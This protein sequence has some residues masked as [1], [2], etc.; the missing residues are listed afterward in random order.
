MGK[1]YDIIVV[2]SGIA[3]LSCAIFLKKKGFS[4]AVLTKNEDPLECNTFY[5]Q[6]GII[7]KVDKDSI[8]LLVNDILLAGNNY[9]YKNAVNFFAEKGPEL[10]PNFL[11]DE[12]GIDFSKTPNGNDIDYTEEA[13]H[14]I[15]RIA[16][17]SDY[18]GEAIEKGL[19]SYAKKIDIKI[20][21]DY[22]AIDLISNTHHSTD[23]QELYKKQIVMGVYALDNKNQK[24]EKILSDKVVLATGGVGNLF[25]YTTN[26]ASA[27]GDGISMAAKAG[28]KIINAE[29]V[30]FHPTML[31]HKDI[32][33]F[34]I[35]ESLRGEGAK[36]IDKNGKTFMQ[37]YSEQ[38]DLAPRDVVSRA[39]FDKMATDAVE[40]VELDIANYYKGE[41]PLKERFA[42]IYQTCKEAGI[43][44]TK[45]KIPVVPGAHYFC[46]G[47][48]VDTNGQSSIEN[49][50]AIGE[51]SCTGLHGSNRLAS[52]SLLEALLWAKSSADDISQN[53]ENTKAKR[54][55]H[56]PD[57]QT[58]KV[59]TTFDPILIKQDWK[60]IK[61]T[62][63]NYAG[64]VRTQKGLERANADLKYFYDRIMRFYSEAT[65]TKDLI[66]LR[67]AVVCSSII[68][69][70]AF[71][72]KN[73]IGC[74]Y[75][76]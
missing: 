44:I 48:K 12:V 64:I 22:S 26:P 70:A 53:F 68:A 58:P 46:G 62:M 49:L 40:Y 28:A 2:G 13:A 35:S 19:Y 18:T 38:K 52:T 63:W 25:Q 14:S 76:K 56:I 11:M 4:V 32:R 74:H 42:K 34:L 72:N 47:I 69:E 54:F 8:D 20:Y 15:R 7:S 30:Q 29:F 9:N 71:K 65:L 61:H 60:T 43:D 6:G 51:V 67:N 33:R 24:V 57:W 17:F 1:K 36:L 27:T 41:K 5:A 37:N 23:K 16:H 59:E 3:G 10:V 50:Y 39:I 31:F 55:A 66:E 73:S 75:I 21:S 45:D